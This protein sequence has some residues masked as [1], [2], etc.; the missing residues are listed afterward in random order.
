MNQNEAVIANQHGEVT[1]LSVSSE[2]MIAPQAP[3]REEIEARQEKLAKLDEIDVEEKQSIVT[4]YWEAEKGDEI[5][6]IFQGWKILEKKDENEEEG[7]KKLPAAV[8]LTKSGTHLLGSTQLVDSFLQIPID[9]AV[10]V[11][12]TGKKGRMKEFDVRLLD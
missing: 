9:S 6:G 5:R 10:Y 12:C 4:S 1:E 2:S 11:K 8:V 7:V 3:S